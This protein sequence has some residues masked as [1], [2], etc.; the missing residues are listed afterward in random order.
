MWGLS[1]W[2]T[3]AWKAS[4]HSCVQ[5]RF[6]FPFLMT[7]EKRGYTCWWLWRWGDSTQRPS[8]SNYGLSWS[9]SRL[10]CPS[11]SGSFLDWL[12]LLSSLLW[13]SRIFRMQPQM[14]T[15]PEWVSY[16]TCGAWRTSLSN[17]RHGPSIVVTLQNIVHIDFHWTPNL[18][19]KHQIHQP[20]V[21]CSSIFQTE[22]HDKITI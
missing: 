9:T 21:S 22:R 20:L 15:L 19:L 16:H 17:H 18:F 1:K 5:A 2:S 10:L 6:F 4:I 14:N 7:L 3:R 8:Y 13:N 12:L 11:M